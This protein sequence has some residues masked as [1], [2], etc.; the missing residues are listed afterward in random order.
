[1]ELN[2]YIDH[3]ILKA[4]ATK[5]QVLKVCEE[6]RKYNF[7]SVCVN[8]CWVATCKKAL[9]GTDVKV[10]TVIGFPLGAMN[11]VAKGYEVKE[12][13]AD[14]ADEFDTVI[15]IGQLKEGN[16]DYVTDDITEVVK[17]AKGRTVKVIIETCLLTD[18]EKVEACK[19]AIRAKADFVKTSTGFSTGGATVEDVKLMHETVKDFGLKVKASGGIRTYADAK[20]M[21]EAGAERLGC[22]AGLKI[23][24]EYKSL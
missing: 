19:C 9:E 6:A 5:R 24:E 2:K 17:A 3:T 12:A 7:A 8:S 14:G 18:E 20:K 23:I 16:L 15:N 1:M 21:I 10:C 22:S 11:S 4:D 13:L